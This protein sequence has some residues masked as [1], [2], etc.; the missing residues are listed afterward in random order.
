MPKDRKST[1][2]GIVLIVVG[3]SMVLGT[4]LAG[5]FGGALRPHPGEAVNQRGMLMVLVVLGGIACVATGLEMLLRD[6]PSAKGS[7]R[8]PRSDDAKLLK[9]LLCP[10]CNAARL[11]GAKFCYMCA[12]P[13]TD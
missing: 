4:M 8:E 13:L 9:L 3:V 5:T 7:P 12:A 2:A 10:K 11:D 6:D 1:L